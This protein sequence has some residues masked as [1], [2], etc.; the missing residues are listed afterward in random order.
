MRAV[1]LVVIAIAVQVCICSQS[2]KQQPLPKVSPK[3]FAVVVK[4]TPDGKRKMIPTTSTK[5][6]LQPQT[7]NNDNETYPLLPGGQ[8]YIKGSEWSVASAPEIDPAK[9]QVDGVHGPVVVFGNTEPERHPMEVKTP[10]V[11][12]S[13]CYDNRILKVEVLSADREIGV[14]R[15][16]LP[17]RFGCTGERDISREKASPAIRVSNFSAHEVV[18]FSLQMISMGDQTCEGPGSETFN[19]IHWHVTGMKPTAHSDKCTFTIQ[20]GASHDRRLLFGGR[21]QPN[22]YLEEYYSGPCPPA[23]TTECFR[24]KVLAHLGDGKTC[25]CGHEDVL[26]YRAPAPPPEVKWV[27]Q[28]PT[29]SP[30]GK[31]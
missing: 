11:D 1:V 17:P 6:A 20:E 22:Q 8:Y 21:E 27:Y 26:F 14:P 2:V 31:K 12:F 5:L 9:K 4:D 28:S 30:V 13:P 24:I 15:A 10:L 7:P 29:L 16:T 23:D 19:R 3:D 25:F 18:E